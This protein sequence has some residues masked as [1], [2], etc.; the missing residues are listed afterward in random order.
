MTYSND[1]DMNVW[2]SRL[3]H[4]EQQRMNRLAKEGHL[5]ALKKVNLPTC[6]NCLEKKMVRKPFGKVIRDQIPL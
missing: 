1:N 2:H 6:P 4:I 3:G 5:G